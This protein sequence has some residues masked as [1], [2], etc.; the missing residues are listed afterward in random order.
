[1]TGATRL[2]D[3]PVGEVGKDRDG[4][5]VHLDELRG[6]GIRRTWKQKG[7]R[8]IV[9]ALRRPDGTTAHIVIS[10]KLYLASCRARSPLSDKSGT[11]T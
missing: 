9:V 6:L 1:M 4:G 5:L 11:A 7:T 3:P 10:P 2:F 8:N